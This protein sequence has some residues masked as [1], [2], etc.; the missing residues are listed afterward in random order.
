[1][2]ICKLRR[3]GLRGGKIKI[4]VGRNDETDALREEMRI[5]EKVPMV[6]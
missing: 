3:A 2:R 6:I 1:M 5:K 4:A